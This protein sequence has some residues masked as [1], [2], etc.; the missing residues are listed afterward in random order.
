[1]RARNARGLTARASRAKKIARPEGAR[2]VDGE[3]VEKLADGDLVRLGPDHGL[4]GLEHRRAAFQP[5]AHVGQVRAGGDA[6]ADDDDASDQR[7]SHDLE[8]GEA[9]RGVQRVIVHDTLPE[10][11]PV[12]RAWPLKVQY[13]RRHFRRTGYST[14]TKHLA[15]RQRSRPGLPRHV[16]PFP[17]HCGCRPST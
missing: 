12:S 15:K 11:L 6:D 4:A 1:M 7:H 14:V 8:V 16:G 2:Q 5:R 13:D 9:V 3:T 17:P 10:F